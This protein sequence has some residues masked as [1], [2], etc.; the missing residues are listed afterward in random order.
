MVGILLGRVP[1]VKLLRTLLYTTTDWFM[2]WVRR[3]LNAV[4]PL[5]PRTALTACITQVGQP[6]A[7]LILR[8]WIITGRAGVR[9]HEG[10]DPQANHPDRE[11]YSITITLP[12]Y[13]EESQAV[14]SGLRVFVL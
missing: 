14:E 7:K 3:F 11:E 8:R 1:I 10:T 2:N 5:K 12:S 13:G 9:A 6:R 4:L